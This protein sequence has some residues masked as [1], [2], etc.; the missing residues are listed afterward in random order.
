MNLT[1]T[2]LVRRGLFEESHLLGTAEN[3]VICCIQLTRRFSWNGD[4]TWDI[5][6]FEDRSHVS[7]STPQWSMK[8]LLCRRSFHTTATMQLG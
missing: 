3:W 2:N 6:R 7:G 1:P 5:E 8:L 4:L